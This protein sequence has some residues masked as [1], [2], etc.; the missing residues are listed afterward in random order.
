[1][2]P[3]PGRARPSG[4]R[5]GTCR[6]SGRR[7]GNRGG[8]R[9]RRDHQITRRSAQRERPVA[10]RLPVHRPGRPA[11]LAAADQHATRVVADQ[12]GRTGDALAGQFDGRGAVR[13]S[14]EPRRHRPAPGGNVSQLD[15]EPVPA[16]E[17]DEH[18][19]KVGVRPG[20]DDPAQRA[21]QQRVEVGATGP[22]GH[23]DRA[24]T[25]GYAGRAKAVGRTGRAHAI[26]RGDRAHAPPGGGLA[27][28]IVPA[29]QEHHARVVVP[30]V[31]RYPSLPAPRRTGAP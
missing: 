18:R 16:Q 21:G 6:C 29:G 17:A 9:P 13:Q 30:H 12:R 24:Q 14:P 4:R 27:A 11:D 1:M 3:A 5:E 31:I 2:A 25:V 22:G 7:P 23:G 19:G 20:D 15:V 28:E 8:I 26:G 10:V